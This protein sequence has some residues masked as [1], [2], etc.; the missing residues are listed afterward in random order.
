MTD[1]R[2]PR[3]KNFLDSEKEIL[4]DLVIPHKSIIENI[5]ASTNPTKKNNILLHLVVIF[6]CVIHTYIL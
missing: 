4:I 1:T 6:N 5:K 2:R 3:G